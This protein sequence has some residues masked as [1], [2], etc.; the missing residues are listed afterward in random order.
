MHD[1]I[2]S[3]PEILWILCFFLA[4]TLSKQIGCFSSCVC[5]CVYVC[6]DP[7]WLVS[8]VWPR[9]L[10][11][12]NTPTSIPQS[13]PLGPGPI[14]GSSG[15]G[16]GFLQVRARVRCDVQSVWGGILVKAVLVPF[17]CLPS[18]AKVSA[19]N[20][21]Q[22]K[23]KKQ[24]RQPYRIDLSVLPDTKLFRKSRVSIATVF[25]N[26]ILYQN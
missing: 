3:K 8:C 10:K 1:F 7:I 11:Y 16:T 6:K 2:W 18:S 15:L 17:L 22:T 19:E 26:G 25:L 13:W 14:T 20:V 21:E 4:T 9:L 23:R 12:Q 24:P 5:V